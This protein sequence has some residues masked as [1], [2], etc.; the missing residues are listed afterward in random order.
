MDMLIFL[1]PAIAACIVLTGIHCY[2]GIH[3][4]MREVIF[5]DL[6]LAQIAALGT[7][8]ALLAGAT[9][10][11][12]GAYFTSLAFT[13]LGAGF[14]SL[15]RFRDRRIPQE[16]VI[17]IA[18]AV[19][20]ALAIL[21]LSRSA[22]EREQIEHMLVGRLLLVMWPD[23]TK[24]ALIYAGVAAIHIV[25]AG[26]FFRLSRAHDATGST[27]LE[28]RAT[29]PPT[30][31]TLVPP[32]LNEGDRIWDFLF[33]ATF[34]VVVTSSVKL[35]GVLLVFSFLIV[36]AACAMLFFRSVRARLLAGWGIGLLGCLVGLLASARMDLPAGPAIVS[37][38]G[39][40]FA[41][42][43]ILVPIV[44]RSARILAGHDGKPS[45]PAISAQTEH[46]DA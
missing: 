15:T 43:L 29:L 40:I 12:T 11:S 36:P 9:P 10:D 17:G 37:A 14:F 22:I 4:L 6:S 7:A 13:L 41:G 34:G 30:G 5:V 46:M 33:Y 20:S 28:S 1:L 21:I 23:V 44:R 24:A 18:Y 32:V 31:E 42:C 35:A 27:A 25:F 38:F 2:L 45:L 19:S 8:V 26:R 16:A 3:V 39:A